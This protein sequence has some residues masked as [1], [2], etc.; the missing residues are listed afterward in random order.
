MESLLAAGVTRRRRASRNGVRLFVVA[1][2]LMAAALTTTPAQAV[3]GME[4]EAATT[5]RVDA[6]KGTVRVQVTAH[7]TNTL[8][9]QTSGAY[10]NTPYFDYFVVPVVGPVKAVR[11]NSSVGG[12]LSVRVEEERGATFLLVDLSPNLVY[13]TPQTITLDFELPGQPPRSKT[14]TRVNPG[15]AGWFVAGLG[16]PG[17]IDITIDV[18][19]SF[20]LSASRSIRPKAESRG[21]RQVYRL[22]GLKDPAKALFFASASNDSRL[23]VRRLEAAGTRVTIKAWPDDQRWQRFAANWVRR[24]LPVLEDLVGLESPRDRLTVLESSRTYHVGYAGAYVPE[25]GIVEVGDLLDESVMLHELTHMWFNDDLFTQRW[26][27]EG[28]AEEFTNRALPKLGEK[29]RPP[30][31]LPA[32]R[33]DATPLNEWE[34]PRPL[35]PT[36]ARIEG[37]AY[38]DSYAVVHEIT[39]E[40]GID[41]LRKVLAAAADGRPAY[42]LDSSDPG[43]TTVRDWRYFYDLAELV[44]GSE[45]V[46]EL[47]NEHVLDDYERSLLRARAGA[48]R[49]LDKLTA[50]SDGWRP[51]LQLRQ[52]MGAWSFSGTFMFDEAEELLK[53]AQNVVEDFA[54]AGIDAERRLQTEYESAA[55]YR[56]L[57]ETLDEYEQAA[58]E[59]AAVAQRAATAGPLARVGLLGADLSLDEAEHAVD[60]GDLDEVAPLLQQTA[61]EIDGATERGIWILVAAALL[62]GVAGAHVLRR[63]ASRRRAEPVGSADGSAPDG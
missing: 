51:P 18:P 42:A 10:I 32:N 50:A 15:F 45:K 12:E 38:N 47:F 59:I 57:G 37:D 34:A 40:I 44:G 62:C 61:D 9:S 55:S 60:E 11:A 13:G 23:S 19:K 14:V 36:R 30:K 28:L 5:Y 4:V 41:G 31:P 20:Q 22:T 54:A 8:P 2:T 43:E 52:A 16:D 33:R 25:L 49:K 35:D 3:E 29:A 63:R 6:A 7:V 56:A 26:I 39:E 58:A 53:R 1:V 21:G 48:R 24:G 46:E 17:N 27:T